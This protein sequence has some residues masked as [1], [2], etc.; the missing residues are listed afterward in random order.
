MIQTPPRTI[1]FKMEQPW[2]HSE[3]D[4]STSMSTAGH[5][6]QEVVSWFFYF[7]FSASSLADVLSLVASPVLYI[8]CICEVNN[9]CCRAA[10]NEVSA[11][12]AVEPGGPWPVVNKSNIW[13]L[14]H[15]DQMYTTHSKSPWSTVHV[16]M[17]MSKGPACTLPLKKIGPNP[18]PKLD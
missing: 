13:T 14:T 3:V 17:S 9:R 7:F 10:S 8:Q 2:T 12:W 5:M 15:D 1:N 11:F 18:Q 16:T 6:A 4:P